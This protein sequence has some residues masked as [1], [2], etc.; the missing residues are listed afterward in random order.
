MK[1]FLKAS[2]RNVLIATYLLGVALVFTLLSF[3]DNNA[4][5]DAAIRRD[6]WS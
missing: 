6:G 1:R 3:L 5:E 4:E 2:L